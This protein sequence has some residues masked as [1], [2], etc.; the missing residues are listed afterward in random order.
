MQLLGIDIGGT[1]CAVVA[2]DEKGNIKEKISFETGNAEY[3]LKK[4]TDI[5]KSF[6]G[7]ERIG[8]SC[9]GPLDAEKG[10]IMSP[11]NLK[12][13]DN[14]PICDMLKNEFGVKCILENDANACAVAEWRFGAGSGTK[15]MVFLTFGTGFGAGLILDGRL[16][17]GTNGNAGEIGHVRLCDYGPV[18]YGKAGSAEGFCSGGGIARIGRM[19]A[20]EKLQ[21]GS[22]VSYCKSADE[23]E[24]ISA[25]SIAQYANA[26]NADAMEVY[27]LSGEKLGEVLSVIIDLLNPEKIII[28]SV[29]ARS[30]NLLWE[31]AKRIIERESLT[32]SAAVCSVEP[33]MLGD[34]IGDYAALA[35]AASYEGE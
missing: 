23:L 14:I 1:K 18:G 4:I 31:H 13:W 28:G 30:K 32:F 29:F 25:K 20:E 6:A 2:G 8:I 27:R 35:L 16:Y 33:A 24:Y 10:I 12:G 15:N 19:M 21:R 34:S 17:R 5:A 9:G 3:S 11:P 26:G 7:F 22:S